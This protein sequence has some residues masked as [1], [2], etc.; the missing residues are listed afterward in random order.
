MRQKIV[1]TGMGV[2]S[3]I[4]HD[5]A[6]NLEALRRGE[7]GIGPVRYL[8]TAH[9][10]F[11]VGE[12]KLS[13]DEMCHRLGL[14]ATPYESRTDLMGL[15][16]LNETLRQAALIGP[17]HTPTADLRIALI[18]ATTVAGMDRTEAFYPDR[19]IGRAHV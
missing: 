4:G 1:V 13:N 12:V 10:E 16:A 7:S 17:D 18:S 3:A 8:S 14:P 19:Q 15:M 6:S 11:P 5:R 2:V 9:T